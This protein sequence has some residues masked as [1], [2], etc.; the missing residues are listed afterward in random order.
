MVHVPVEY[1]QSYQGPSDVDKKAIEPEGVQFMQHVSRCTFLGFCNHS[2]VNIE[3]LMQERLVNN[4]LPQDVAE[5]YLIHEL[6]PLQPTLKRIGAFNSY[7]LGSME[8]LRATIRKGDG[9]IIS[10]ND[11]RGKR[12]A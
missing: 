2:D 8:A 9:R 7:M 3:K 12:A 11:R 1:Q 10:L 6:R 4:A 5:G